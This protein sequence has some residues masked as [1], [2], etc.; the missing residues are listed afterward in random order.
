MDVL[1][2]M[3]GIIGKTYSLTLDELRW[4]KQ[5]DEERNETTECHNCADEDDDCE[6]CIAAC[7]LSTKLADALS[8]AEAGCQISFFI[9]N[10]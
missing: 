6:S 10:D 5:I 8:L 1:K 3:E 4:L 7:K 2:E 9:A